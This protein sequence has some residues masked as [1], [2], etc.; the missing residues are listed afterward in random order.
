MSPPVRQG[1]PTPDT[2]GDRLCQGCGSALAADNTA[3]LC[4][5]CHREQRD[6]LRTPPIQRNEFFETA[7]FRA[8]F[9][10]QHIGKVFKAYR[11]HPR[12]L[13]LFG[14]ALNQELLGRWLGLTQ[15]QVS[16]LESGKPEL[17]LDTLRTYARI[18]HL[19]QHLLWFDF[20]GQ[21]RLTKLVQASRIDAPEKIV[22][23]HLSTRPSLA[24]P[25]LNFPRPLDG[26][27]T[28]GSTFDGNDPVLQIRRLIDARAHF[29]R[30]YR[31][32]GGLITGAR[33]EQFLARQ[34]LPFTTGL[35]ASSDVER[36]SIRATGSLVALAGVCAYDSEDWNTANTHFARALTI[37]E[38]SQDYS[39]HSYVVALMVN[40]ALALEDYKTAEALANVGLLT[41]TKT[42]AAQLTID[43]QAMRAKALASMGDRTA[44]MSAI[45]EL[46]SAVGMTS[47]NQDIAEASYVQE[48]HLQAQLA[49]ALTSLG[50]LQA[51]SRYAEQSILSDGHTRGKVNRLASM[52]TLEVA[53]GEI[54]RASLLACEMVDNA[55]GMESRRLRSRFVKIRADLA[56]R[57]NAASREALDR[58]DVALT[59]MP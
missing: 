10:S 2:G 9:E 55:Q 50:D 4:S 26:V 23:G 59:L 24:V 6:Q 22:T 41:S 18:L 40:Q 43:L 47:N 52:A 39:F 21:S 3:Q 16:K 49:E 46:E 51:A 31:N 12:H 20:P 25:L 32:S 11:N 34:A 1:R 45:Q 33:I 54:E 14:K 19:P 30:M 8:A 48:G 38:A 15:S 58:L 37:A 36:R 29:E 42:A 13:L 57:P 5:R 44:A 28:N 7:E 17:N 35:G 27:T 56:R 53:R